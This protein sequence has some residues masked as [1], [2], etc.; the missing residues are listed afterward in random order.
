MAEK[1]QKTTIST[2]VVD[3]MYA[4]YTM[5][6]TSG[7]TAIR[8]ADTAGA[9]DGSRAIY[10]GSAFIA[11]SSVT[12]S[13]FANTASYMVIE[14]S[15][16][17]PSG[18]RW[19]AKISRGAANSNLYV[20]FAPRG[21]WNYA[22]PGFDTANYPYTGDLDALGA[23]TTS[24]RVLVSTSDLDTY[25]SGT[26][27]SYLRV[28]IWDSAGSAMLKSLYVG[29]YIPFDQ[30]NNTNPAV[31]L[32]RSPNIGA[33]TT[34]VSWG[35]S[36]S[37]A[38]NLNRIPPDYTGTAKNLTAQGYAYLATLDTSYAHRDMSGNWCNMPVYIRCID[39]AGFAGY[40]GK[41]SMFAGDTGRTLATAD[42]AAE[43]LTCNDLVLRWKPSA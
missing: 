16:A 34:T 30:T 5:V 22:T 23:A 33:G 25:G 20:N 15:V 3:I 39:D 7:Q 14:S 29:G 4:I 41:Y 28:V 40:F 1:H 12:S 9:A 2:G 42:S 10:S 21:S 6:Q 32:I 37:G 27:Y 11:A 38:S 36:T 35:Y 17:M 8:W 19:Q 18:R 13:T 31:A 26:T 24:G 43:Y